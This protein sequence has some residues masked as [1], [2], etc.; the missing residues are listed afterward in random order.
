MQ[1]NKQINKEGIGLGLFIT[2]NLV[3][4]LGGKITVDSREGHYT[5]FIVT[6]PV[7]KG[8]E[9]SEQKKKLLLE[10]GISIKGN[11]TT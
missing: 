4:E 10:H 11:Q 9:L 6:L 8:F 5:R 7:V 2:K 3:E 1:K